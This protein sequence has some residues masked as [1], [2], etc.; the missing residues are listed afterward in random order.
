MHAC[1]RYRRNTVESILK[2]IHGYE[3]LRLVHRLDKVTSGVMLFAKTAEAARHL[4]SQI[5]SPGSV[6]KEY[7]ARVVG[8]F[9]GGSSGSLTA[10]SCSRSFKDLACSERLPTAIIQCGA[11]L[12]VDP[13]TR[14][15]YVSGIAAAGNNDSCGDGKRKSAPNSKPAVTEFQLLS[16]EDVGDGSVSL[17]RVVTFSFLCPLLEKYGTFIARCNALIEKVSSFRCTACPR[18]AERTRLGRTWR[19]SDTR[20]LM[21]HSTIQSVLGLAKVSAALPHWQSADTATQRPFPSLLSPKPMLQQPMRLQ[22]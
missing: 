10:G 12:I 13:K 16:T 22:H 21:I 2:H 14:R 18:R 6:R 8:T 5:Q 11:P 7:L 15:V 19:T 1:G 4:T 17:V 20:L 3:N 9:P